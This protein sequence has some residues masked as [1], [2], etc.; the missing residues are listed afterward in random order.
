MRIRGNKHSIDS[1]RGDGIRLVHEGN[2]PFDIELEEGESVQLLVPMS[3]GRTCV[4][5]EVICGKLRI[6]GGASIIDSIEGEG[7]VDLVRG[8][9]AGTTAAMKDANTLPITA[10]PRTVKELFDA[11]PAEPGLSALRDKIERATG[12]LTED[13][14]EKW[15]D[16]LEDLGFA[17]DE[18]DQI[19]EVLQAN[20]IEE[21]ETIGDD[22]DR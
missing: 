2:Q 15:P 8:L 3:D 12:P 10:Y 16:E 17:D 6:T 4:N 21:N 13:L 7:M 5:L 22:E 18:I 11:A 1:S 19:T 14:L 9:E 20:G